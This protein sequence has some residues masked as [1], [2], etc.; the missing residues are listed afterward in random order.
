MLEQLS[1]QRR[2]LLALVGELRDV[3]RSLGAA[4]LMRHLTRDVEAKLEADRFFLVVVGEFNHG[5]TALVNALLGENV[6]PVG[7]TPTTAVIHQ[8]AYADTPSARIVR[9]NGDFQ[10]FP[11]EQLGEFASGKDRAGEPVAHLE[12]G[13]PAE[14]LREQVVLVDTPGVNDLSLIRADI[15]CG[16]LPRADAVLFVLDAGQPLKESEREFLEKQLER[17]GRDNLLFVVNKSDLWN[18]E[19]R[20]EALTYVRQRLADLLDEPAVF[21]VSARAALAG[22]EESSGMPELSAQIT[23]LLTQQRGQLVL[24]N[25]I[26]AVAL[27]EAALRH[28]VEARRRAANL[29][30]E[31]LGSRIASL[32]ADLA[33]H[34]GA[35]D[36][37]QQLVREETAAIKAWARRD[38]QRFCDDLLERLPGWLQ[39]ARGEDVREHLGAFLETAFRNWAQAEADEISTALEELAE[40]V[41]ALLREDSEAAGRRVG[42]ALG[43]EFEPPV[44]DVDTFMYDMGVFAVLSLG[45]GVVFANVLLG[46]VL[47]AA[48]PA[49]ALFTRDRADAEIR[50]R[51]RELAPTVLTETA[52]KVAPRL[53]QMVDEARY[54]LEEWIVSVGE[55]THRE[56]IEVLER[57]REQ[58]QAGE[59]DP[60]AIAVDCDEYRRRLS[61]LRDRIG[62]LGAPR[63][64]AVE[65]EQDA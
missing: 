1:A 39:Q 63:G 43:S 56:L 58:R 54:H 13:Y 42:E 60:A 5:K 44:I 51:A 22:S 59:L 2:E 20:E 21:A 36:A 52:G 4:S 7:V 25:A 57:S 48:A 64:G 45:L 19:E 38:L 55:R 16:Y 3:A 15:T 53:D 24:G 50:R 31:Q 32:Q 62:R 18:A 35:I 23:Q 17:G 46:G 49:L 47:L 10:E 28:A 65:S 8:L 26:S 9:P 11:W 30:L 37:R 61:V 34:R 12:I 29:S 41:A 6:L 27:A 40:R 14:L 33:G